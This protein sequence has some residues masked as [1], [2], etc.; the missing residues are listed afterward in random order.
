MAV[1]F[2]GFGAWH[3]SDGSIPEHGGS[4]SSG[5]GSG[6]GGVWRWLFPLP[7]GEDGHAVLFAQVLLRPLASF[8]LS[9]Q[10]TFFLDHLHHFGVSTEP[11]H[12]ERNANT[13]MHK[14][15]LNSRCDFRDVG[16]FLCGGFLF[17]V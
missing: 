12:L 9:T 8:D 11:R 5:S 16:L 13:N 3:L 14:L 4:V 1:S 2:C 17:V 10:N 15:P 7:A 6:R